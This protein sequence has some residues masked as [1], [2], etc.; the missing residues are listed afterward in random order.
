MI[1]DVFVYNHLMSRLQRDVDKFNDL[2]FN[3][4]FLDKLKL[5]L[6]LSKNVQ[7]LFDKHRKAIC[8]FQKIKEV[9][10]PSELNVAIVKIEKQLSSIL[11]QAKEM[12][13]TQV[14]NALLKINSELEVIKTSQLTIDQVMKLINEAFTAAKEFS[15]QTSETAKGSLNS[16]IEKIKTQLI[17]QINKILKDKAEE[18][19]KHIDKLLIEKI[20]PDKED[21]DEVIQA[22]IND[23][24]L[25]RNDTINEDFVFYKFTM[26]DIILS[27][28]AVTLAIIAVT[29]SACLCKLASLARARKRRKNNS[30]SFNDLEL[31]P[32]VKKGI[33]FGKNK[34]KE[35]EHYA[36]IDTLPS[37]EPTVRKSYTKV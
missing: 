35:Y 11:S 37:P 34:V 7:T 6:G 31:S 18:N 13:N 19:L 17:S 4:Q 33:K 15:S 16:R 14:T 8:F 26:L 25:N 2:V 12:T 10:K 20:P 30:D 5:M 21:I 22:K 32:I 3:F 29:N 27:S 28:S 1:N 9:T 24:L 36:S 23:K